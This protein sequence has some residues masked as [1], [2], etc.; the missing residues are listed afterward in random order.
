MKILLSLGF[1]FLIFI[2]SEH[3]VLNTIDL[4]G[5]YHSPLNHSNVLNEQLHLRENETFEY[6]YE[7][8]NSKTSI[9]LIYGKYE[10]TG[11]QI[12]FFPLAFEHQNGNLAENK[13]A[14]FNPNWIDQQ[15]PKSYQSLMV[16]F[17]A[18]LLML[19]PVYTFKKTKENLSICRMSIKDERFWPV[20]EK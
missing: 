11:Q 9:S 12:Q 4:C 19:K 16:N 13:D 5:F 8:N 14:V 6:R 10:V 7:Y 1:A 3:E 15:T 20:F 18:G 17:E 2:G